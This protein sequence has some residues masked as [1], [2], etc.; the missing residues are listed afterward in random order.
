MSKRDD[1]KKK[2]PTTLLTKHGTRGE[3]E[4]VLHC[5]IAVQSCMLQCFLLPPLPPAP[6]HPSQMKFYV[7]HQNL[8]AEGRFVLLLLLFLSTGKKV[9]SWRE[10]ERYRHYST[11]CCLFVVIR[12][13]KE[14]EREREGKRDTTIWRQSCAGPRA[15]S[16]QRQ[17]SYPATPVGGSFQTPGC[18]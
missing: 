11:L 9:L 14:R 6:A 1:P 4:P 13:T 10:G 5:N 12:L 8:C 7:H 2:Q 17:F 18:L 3:E 16:P 15:G